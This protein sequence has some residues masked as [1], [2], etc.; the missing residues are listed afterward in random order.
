[1][2]HRRTELAQWRQRVAEVAEVC[3]QSAPRV[4]WR[5]STSYNRHADVVGIG[6]FELRLRRGSEPAR[7]AAIAHELG[8][9]A[10]AY[11]KDDRIH[12]QWARTSVRVT[13]AAVVL[14]EAVLLTILGT[15]SLLASGP[16]IAVAW[17]SVVLALGVLGSVLLAPL[18][19]EFHGEEYAA[20]DYAA[21]HTGTPGTVESL[22]QLRTV[23]EPVMG[24]IPVLSTHPNTRTRIAR[25][26]TRAA[27]RDAHTDTSP[28]VSGP[29][30]SVQPST[31]GGT[32]D[33]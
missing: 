15:T 12:T 21:D 33:E 31:Q 7:R 2:R 23:W 25:Q 28:D 27:T 18:L 3:G 13:A 16:S 30:A 22:W 1:M 4:A 19:G 26:H 14:I 32:G 10:S 24:R 20:D 6:R 5:A 11:R 17:F 8:H 29:V 9:R